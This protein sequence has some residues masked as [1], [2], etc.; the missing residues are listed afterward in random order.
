MNRSYDKDTQFQIE[1][2]TQQLIEMLMEERG[3]SMQEAMDI[4]YNSHTYEKVERPATGM[5]YQAPVYV[6]DILEDELENKDK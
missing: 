4:V 6:M 1:F 3:L 2:L 5:Y